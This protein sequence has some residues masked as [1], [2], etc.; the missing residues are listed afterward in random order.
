VEAA[1][2]NMEMEELNANKNHSS[3]SHGPADTYALVSALRS[4]WLDGGRVTLAGAAATWETYKSEIPGVCHC[5][6]C[7]SASCCLFL[8]EEDMNEFRLDASEI[9]NQVQKIH[10]KWLERTLLKKQRE[11]RERKGLDTQMARAVRVKVAQT[12]SKQKRVHLVNKLRT[13]AAD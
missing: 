3:S 8:A 11:R 6:V 4:I 1:P 10:I 13:T 7:M 12:S 2:T 5:H 9:L